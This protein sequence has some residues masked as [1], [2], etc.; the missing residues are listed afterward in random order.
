M[1]YPLTKSKSN[2]QS[3]Y[4]LLKEL[5]TGNHVIFVCGEVTFLLKESHCSEGLQAQMR[6]DQA[7][8]RHDGQH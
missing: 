5:E 8:M 4:L 2:L 6:A 3:R 1:L 7:L